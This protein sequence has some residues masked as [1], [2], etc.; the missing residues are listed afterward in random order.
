MGS[1]TS[2]SWKTL[3]W[4]L[5]LLMFVLHQ[6]KWWWDDETLVLGFLPVGLAFH[7]LFSIG[8][9]ALGWLAIKI[10]WPHDLEAFAEESISEDTEDTDQDA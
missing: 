7:A 10:A 3:V 4:V 1:S 8:C 9:A 2:S 6:D 5:F